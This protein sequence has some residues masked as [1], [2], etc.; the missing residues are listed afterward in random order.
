MYLLGKIQWSV[1]PTLSIHFA[2]LLLS[3]ALRDA[4]NK[5][6]SSGCCQTSSEMK[7]EGA[8]TIHLEGTCRAAVV[9]PPVRVRLAKRHINA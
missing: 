3:I 5:A 6:T 7:K 9:K 1:K 4:G 2:E 8:H